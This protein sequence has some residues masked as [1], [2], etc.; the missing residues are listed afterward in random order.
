MN[1]SEDALAPVATL[2]DLLGV[3]AAQGPGRCAY[4]FLDEDEAEGAALT[5]G[6]LHRQARDLGARLQEAGAG[7]QRVLILC[8][9]GPEFVVSFFGCLY[10]GGVPVP[11]YPPRPHRT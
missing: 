10:G 3:R 7:G 1:L 4:V 8:P 9:T 5:F 11:A 2:V 6:D